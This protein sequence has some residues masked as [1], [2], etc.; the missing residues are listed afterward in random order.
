MQQSNIKL[1]KLALSESKLRGLDPQE[2]YVFAL[3]GH[4]FNELMM[5]QKVLL[6]SMPAPGSHPFVQDAGVDVS[7]FALRLLVGKTEE[8]MKALSKH[9]VDEVL[10][11]K[12]FALR[13]GIEQR[14]KDAQT[15][16][17]TMPWLGR[18]RNQRAFHYMT[19]G[20]WLPHFTDE[21]FGG[22]YVIVGTTHGNTLF[23]WQEVSAGLP[24]LKL[25]NEAKPFDGLDLMLREMGDLLRELTA[26]LA[27]G[28]QEYMHQVLTDDG[29]L[30][31]PEFLSA[32][33]IEQTYMPYY[34]SK[35]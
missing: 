9:S 26:C 21:L 16:Y 19:A 25:V 27:E 11:S 33:S 22:A 24:M 29:A 28:M 3:A 15:Q 1:H 7:L 5:L 34:F 8:A 23:Q 10:R 12:V 18:I 20:Q 31:E 2:L 32:A 35:E 30:S 13:P 4:V 6:T 17:Q 14:W